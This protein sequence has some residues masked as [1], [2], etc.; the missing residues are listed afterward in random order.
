MF[1]LSSAFVCRILGAVFIV[2][3]LYLVLWGKT[4][5]KKEANQEKEEESLTKHLLEAESKDKESANSSDIP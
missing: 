3:G 2:A 1:Q 4:E 5:E